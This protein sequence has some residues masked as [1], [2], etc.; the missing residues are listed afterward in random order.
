MCREHESSS[1][2]LEKEVGQ[3]LL[4]FLQADTD[5]ERQQR[6]R[7]LESAIRRLLVLRSKRPLQTS[8]S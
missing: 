7:F 4:S 5:E 8:R 2:R 6:L 1:Q 3:L